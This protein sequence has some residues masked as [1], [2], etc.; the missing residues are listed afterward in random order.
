[1]T[2]PMTALQRAVYQAL[3]AELSCPV[4][5]GVP[6]GTDYPY[7]TIDYQ[8]AHSRD[9][10][11]ARKN[12]HMLYLSVWSSYQGQGEV[13]GIMSDIYDSL[14][15]R[16]LFLDTGRAISV[17]VVSSATN[18]E[19]DGVTYQGQVRVRVRTENG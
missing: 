13:L 14:H 8:E 6:Q 3:T 11:S 16:R 4:F 5:D 18:R 15:R 7:I 9:Y 10:L 19:P 2:Q 12:E 1:M 17:S